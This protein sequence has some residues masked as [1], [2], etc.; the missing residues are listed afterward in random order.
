MPSHPPLCP[1]SVS[2]HPH[3]I[4][5][6]TLHAITPT[7]M[8][9]LRV[10]SPTLHNHTHPSCHRT[11][12]SFF[13]T[14]PN[15]LF[16]CPVTHPSCHHTHPSCH[17][18]HP[19]CHHTHPYGLPP[20]PLNHPSCH[21][22]HP[23]CHHTH[24]SCHHTH[25][26]DPAPCPLTHSPHGQHTSVWLLAAGPASNQP[27]AVPAN[28]IKAA[29]SAR[30]QMYY[31]PLCNE[32]HPPFP[33]PP[34]LRSPPHSLTLST[35]PN[36]HLMNNEPLHRPVELLGKPASAC[37]HRQHACVPVVQGR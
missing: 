10:L 30:L 27:G 24:P 36:H 31:A 23:S 21:H 28:A 34:P 16:P 14:Y 7:L 25:P 1:I 26:Y 12:F 11:F 5:T 19:Q 29:G 33:P 13:P 37:A 8:P 3:F 22:T 35:D 9:Y 17:H 20:C 2:S 6:H 4:I 32:I 18:T 15:G